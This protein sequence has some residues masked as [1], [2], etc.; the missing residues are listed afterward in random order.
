MK[1]WVKVLFIVFGSIIVLV[2][3]IALC[4]SQ[5][6]KSYI[7]KHDKELIGRK[8]RMGNL[9][10]NIFE[11]SVHFERLKIYEKDDTNKFVTIDSFYFNMNIMPLLK[12]K[13]DVQRIFWVVQILLLR[14]RILFSILAI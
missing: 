7:E 13:L 5:I 3:A 11:G 14:K 2:F 4:I 12:Q 6:A 9:K 1:S 10:I 8:L